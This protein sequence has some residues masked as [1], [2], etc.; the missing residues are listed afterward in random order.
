MVA[1]LTM[2]NLEEDWQGAAAKGGYLSHSEAS[3]MPD[4][5]GVV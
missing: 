5:L 4:L 3:P 1:P 2:F